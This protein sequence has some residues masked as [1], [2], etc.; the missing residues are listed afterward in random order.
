M[1]RTFFVIPFVI[2]TIFPGTSLAIKFDIWETGMSINEV[3]S[4]ARQY[5]I[6]IASDAILH[7]QKIRD[8]S[9]IT[10]GR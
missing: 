8:I 6:P 7:G 3:V 10:E 5:D 4:L 9:R 2:S 1:K